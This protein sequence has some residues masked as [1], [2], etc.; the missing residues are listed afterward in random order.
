MDKLVKSAEIPIRQRLVKKPI[1][2]V[3]NIP[4]THYKAFKGSLYEPFLSGFRNQRKVD[5]TNVHFIPNIVSPLF[6][7]EERAA[8]MAKRV[9]QAS[10]KIDADKVHIVTHSF[11]GVDARAALSLN[12]MNKHVQSLTTL[13]TPHHGMRLID[14]IKRYPSRYEIDRLEKAIEQLGLG[15]KS[16]EEFQSVNIRDF[17]EFCE[18]CP[19]VDYYSFGTKKKELQISELLRGGYSIIT[20]YRM[21]WECDGL[22]EVEE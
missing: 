18:D 9:E 13:S 7:I 3:L 11:A 16:V 5:A 10:E 4:T 17:N 15:T 14:M 1:F 8:Q 20:D 22:C 6:T 2:V 12:G 21:E 19:D